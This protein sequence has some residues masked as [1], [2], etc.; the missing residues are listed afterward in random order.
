MFGTPCRIE[1]PAPRAHGDVTMA[2]DDVVADVLPCRPYLQDSFGRR[3]C[4][5]CRHSSALDR[6][7]HSRCET[8]IPPCT[9]TTDTGEII[10]FL[11]RILG[12]ARYSQQH[13]RDSACRLCI[14]RGRAESKEP[15]MD[16]Y[17][18]E[19]QPVLPPSRHRHHIISNLNSSIHIWKPSKRRTHL[20]VYILG[21]V[22]ALLASFWDCGK[23]AAQLCFNP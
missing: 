9:I 3:Y 20:T 13:P 6:E 22:A 5:L 15:I 8:I 12:G 17:Q 23:V 10:C 2:A 21:E 19:D 14:H 7:I 1:L 11:P 16:P 4:H 18:P